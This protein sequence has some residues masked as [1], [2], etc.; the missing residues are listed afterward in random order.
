MHYVNAGSRAGLCTSLYP[1]TW[2]S[3]GLKGSVFPIEL[4]G[5]PNEAEKEEYVVD[6]VLKYVHAAK[7]PVILVGAGAIRHSA[8]DVV[9]E[10]IQEV[11]CQHSLRPMGKG[12]MDEALPNFGAVHAGSGFDAGVS[13]RVEMYT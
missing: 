6:V 2:Y 13:E 12:A 3:K 5:P 10:L 8:L 4:N 11:N 9:H 7:N 1:P